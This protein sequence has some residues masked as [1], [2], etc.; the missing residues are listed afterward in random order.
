V[1]K[2]WS[3]AAAEWPRA[4]AKRIADKIRRIPS[5]FQRVIQANM[6]QGGAG[7]KNLAG[8][9]VSLNF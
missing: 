6:A 3:L 7:N 9:W 8:A 1:K 2:D 5:A 4:S